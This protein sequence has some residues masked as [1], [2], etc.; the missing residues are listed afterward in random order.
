MAAARAL[1]HTSN[2]GRLGPGRLLQLVGDSVAIDGDKLRCHVTFRAHFPVESEAMLPRLKV[3]VGLDVG[4]AGIRW[5]TPDTLGAPSSV[6]SLAVPKGPTLADTQTLVKDV[7]SS[8]TSVPFAPASSRPGFG[9]PKSNP[10]PSSSAIPAV[11]YDPEWGDTSVVSAADARRAAQ[12]APVPF[13]PTATANPFISEAEL[14][15]TFVLS[16]EES[17]GLAASPPAPPPAVPPPRISV[18]KVSVPEDDDDD[19]GGS[20][21]ILSYEEVTAASKAGA[22]PFP[23]AIKR[24]P[25]SGGTT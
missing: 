14:E 18:P 19:L 17:Q 3:V 24:E 11:K 2:D 7:P 21:S 12:R 20:T 13:G 25:G 5:P 6:A 15:G 9:P 1:V 16:A 8:P 23:S 4:G 10:S 22:I